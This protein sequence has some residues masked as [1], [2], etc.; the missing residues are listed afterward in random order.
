MQPIAEEYGTINLSRFS[1]SGYVYKNKLFKGNINDLKV[2]DPKLAIRMSQNNV[3]YIYMASLTGSN[4]GIGFL[5]VTYINK[6][7][8]LNIEGKIMDASQKIS[9]L[10]D[11]Y[12]SAK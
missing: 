6:P 5:G 2:I 8:N 10:L 12:Q 1:F 7:I 9:I 3:K 11:L 4:I